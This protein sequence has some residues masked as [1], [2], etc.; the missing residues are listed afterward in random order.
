MIDNVKKLNLL[1]QEIW[2]NSSDLRE[3]E[4]ELKEIKENAASYYYN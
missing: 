2:F 3:Y 1:K 4:I